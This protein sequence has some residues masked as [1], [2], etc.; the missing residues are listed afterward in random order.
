[1]AALF[2]SNPKEHIVFREI[3]RQIL[4]RGY[5]RTTDTASALRI[6]LRVA[7]KYHKKLE[8][9]GILD[10]RR[11]NVGDRYEWRYEWGAELIYFLKRGFKPIV[12]GVRM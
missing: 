6:S 8:D 11:V 5:A 2:A 7:Q 9:R 1:M 10:K 3:F 12:K 4:A